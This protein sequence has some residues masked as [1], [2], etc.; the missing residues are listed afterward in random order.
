MVERLPSYTSSVQLP[1]LQNLKKFVMVNRYSRNILRLA[2]PPTD[3]KQQFWHA[4][5]NPTSASG[6]AVFIY[7]WFKLFYLIVL[8]LLSAL[9][10]PTSKL[11]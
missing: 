5:S 2:N 3:L 4:F 7:P 9:L 11:Q 10:L 8:S 1:S 6:N